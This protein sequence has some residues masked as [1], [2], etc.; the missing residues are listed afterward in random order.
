MARAESKK[1]GVMLVILMASALQGCN[2]L[3]S[4]CPPP[5]KTEKTV[6]NTRTVEPYQVVGSNVPRPSMAEV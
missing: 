6:S 3:K 5:A 2:T 1:L 4:P